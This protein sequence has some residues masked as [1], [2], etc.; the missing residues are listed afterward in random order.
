VEVL[1]RISDLRQ[2]VRS[3]RAAGSV[4]GLVPTMG[5]FHEGHLSLMR[6]AR[7]ECGLVI[8][9][10][11]VNPTQFGANEDLSRYPRDLDGDR[12]MAE[13]TGA[14]VLFAPPVEEVYPPDASTW[15][16]VE[17]LTQGLCGRARPT[18]FRGVTTVV[19]KLFNMAQPDR[20]YFGEKDYQQLQVIRRMVRDL[21]FSV[22]IVPCPIY[23]EPDGLAMSSRNRYL[24]PEQRQAALALSRGLAAAREQFA[25]GER[26]AAALI[27]AVRRCLDAELLVREEYV[28]VVDAESLQSI[29]AVTQPAV[30][31]VAAFVGQTR[32]IDNLRLT[33]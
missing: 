17:G 13:G 5:A 15:V 30:L 31:A 10:L 14:D 16:T 1:T 11:F 33:P 8:V 21:D 19:A 20:A 9:T 12:R 27:R 32:L 4:I 28:E 29:A 25:G 3:A 23:R 22:E 6:R 7:E 24:S 18:H 2:R 26:E